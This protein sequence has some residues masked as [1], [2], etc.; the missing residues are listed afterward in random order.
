MSN[1]TQFCL[2]SIGE[3]RANRVDNIHSNKKGAACKETKTQTTA[4]ASKQRRCAVAPCT[5]I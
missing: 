1:I 5:V 4:M 3:S 2:K